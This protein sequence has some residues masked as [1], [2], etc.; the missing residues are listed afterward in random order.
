MQGRCLVG[1]RAG[2]D[3]T[4]AALG[5]PRQE[6]EQGQLGWRGRKGSSLGPQVRSQGPSFPSRTPLSAPW[7]LEDVT[8]FGQV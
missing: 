3:A 4:E 2:E 7:A 8:A 5:S 1:P 6:Q